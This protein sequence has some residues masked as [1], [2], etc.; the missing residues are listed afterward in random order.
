MNRFCRDCEGNPKAMSWRCQSV[1][2]RPRPL[3]F[4]SR[5]FECIVQPPIII[6]VVDPG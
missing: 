1:S 3:T 4:A 6:V 2:S 5:A